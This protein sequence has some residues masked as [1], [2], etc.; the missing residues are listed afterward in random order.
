MTLLQ[1]NFCSVFDIAMNKTETARLV[2]V[3]MHT[4]VPSDRAQNTSFR[5]VTSTLQNR[6]SVP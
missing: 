6:L 1:T 2:S 3:N 5:S 4:A